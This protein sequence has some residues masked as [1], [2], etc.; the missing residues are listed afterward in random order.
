MHRITTFAHRLGD[1]LL[2][3]LRPVQLMLA[4]SA[5]VVATVVAINGP[6]VTAFPASYLTANIYATITIFVVYAGLS[7]YC[8][9]SVHRSMFNPIIQYTTAIVGLILWTTAFILEV[10]VDSSPLL[11]LYIVPVLAECWVLAQLMSDVRSQ[12]RRVL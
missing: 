5:L 1:I 10:L 6:V 11:G 4:V 12:D 7:L 9:T 2:L 3:S 8:S